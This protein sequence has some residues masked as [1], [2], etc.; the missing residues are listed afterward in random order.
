MDTRRD[1]PKSFEPVL[2][3]PSDIISPFGGRRG[4]L[5]MKERDCRNPLG[6]VK[7]ESWVDEKPKDIDMLTYMRLYDTQVCGGM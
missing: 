5:E 6:R 7:N 4:E 3:L 2:K 1:S